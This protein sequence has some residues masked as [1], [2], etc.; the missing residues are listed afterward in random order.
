MPLIEDDIIFR[1]TRE[2]VMVVIE[3]ISH[4]GDAGLSVIQEGAPAEVEM[5]VDTG[6]AMAVAIL[7]AAAPWKLK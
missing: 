7:R 5:S 3:D 1:D 2:N 6:I 4:G